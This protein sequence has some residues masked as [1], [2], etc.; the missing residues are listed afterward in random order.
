MF[1]HK[2][3]FLFGIVLLIVFTHG[4][5]LNNDLEDELDVNNEELADARSIPD[6][7]ANLDSDF[8]DQL[9]V[10]DVSSD[11]N[12][13]AR[14]RISS[15]KNTVAGRRTSS[16][17]PWCKDCISKILR[18]L[19]FFGKKCRRRTPTTPPTRPPPECSDEGCDGLTY[20]VNPPSILLRLQQEMLQAHNTYRARH[21][22]PS[23]TLDENLN[24]RAQKYA[25]YLAYIDKMVACNNC[26]FG[27]NLYVQNNSARL[28]GK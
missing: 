15:S 3:I 28:D 9:E 2:C 19:C 24:K 23:L 7:N 11:E 10:R 1:K 13:V 25:G 16:S 17:E 20:F 26:S 18:K 6:A 22:A 8:V 4:V 5:P 21:C 12:T 27:Q 14:R